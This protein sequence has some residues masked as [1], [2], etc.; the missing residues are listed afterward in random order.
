MIPYLRTAKPSELRGVVLLRLDLN[1]ADEWRLKAEIPTIR[2]LLRHAASI[3]IVSHRGRPNPILPFLRGVPARGEISSPLRNSRSAK[4]F[5]LRRDAAT[6][7]KYLRRPVKLI[8]HFDF[9]HIAEEVRRAPRKSVFLLENIRFVE[10]ET[11]N[12]E[13]L[14]KQLAGIADFY[15]NDA[16]AVSHR[17]NASVAAITK[18]LPSF[19]GLE[20]EEEIRMLSRVMRRPKRPLAVIVGG[21]KAEDKLG[22][23]HYF[24]HKADWI[25]LGGAT[26][27]AML[28]IKGVQVGSSLA[29]HGIEKNPVVREIE[30][31][32]HLILPI[33]WKAEKGKIFD[34]GAKTEKLFA[35]KIAGARTIIW[36][37]PLGLM[38]KKKFAHGSVAIARM[39]IANKHAFR[40]VGGGETVGFLYQHHLEHKF[41]FVSTGGGAMLDFLSGEKLPGIRALSGALKKRKQKGN[42]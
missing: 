4:K 40:L 17:A 38:E 9:P 3:I 8:Q 6:L 42:S 36:N 41:D 13:K 12:D 39:I 29:A 37:G 18:F 28:R 19:A 16:F 26:A 24:K 23:L 15:V 22:L 27:N 33:D 10:G 2:F 11:E 20:F 14:A 21:A 25:M 34:I 7:S 32:P 31:F 1:T 30:K 35:K 5:S